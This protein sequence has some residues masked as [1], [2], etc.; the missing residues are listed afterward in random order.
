MKGVSF[1]T[2]D[3]EEHKSEYEQPVEKPKKEKKRLSRV[4]EELK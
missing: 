4:D 2:S 1:A 3:T